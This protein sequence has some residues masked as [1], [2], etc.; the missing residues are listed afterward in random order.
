MRKSILAVM[1]LI[2][3]IFLISCGENSDISIK[4][5]ETVVSAKEF[6]SVFEVAREGSILKTYKEKDFNF[7]Y[8]NETTE[9]TNSNSKTIYQK[10]ELE[11]DFDKKSLK[12]IDVD[13]RDGNKTSNEVKIYCE[14]DKYYSAKKGEEPVEMN[15]ES[16]NTKYNMVI[17]QI[18][19]MIG[20]TNRFN[21][22]GYTY[23]VDGNVYTAVLLI[24]NNMFGIIKSETIIQCV[25][26]ED[27][28][29]IIETFELENAD[30]S[31]RSYTKTYK[32]EIK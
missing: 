1:L 10:F 32:L 30:G 25:F 15:E 13:E 22:S 6:N 31:A 9:K 12:Q 14:D 29:S 23:Y 7:Q 16:F 4:K 3:A 11:H 27:S 19:T 20:G 28:I 18:A 21:S 2:L 24:G 26:E 5:Y 17:N 8:I